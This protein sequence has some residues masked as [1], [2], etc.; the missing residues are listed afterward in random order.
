MVVRQ[1]FVGK[2]GTRIF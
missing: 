1:E 2:V